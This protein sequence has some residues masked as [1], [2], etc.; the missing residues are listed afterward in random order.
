MSL[1]TAQG[2]PA[3]V[4]RPI[5]LV[6]VPKHPQRLVVRWLGPWH[7][8][9]VHHRPEKIGLPCGQGWVCKECQSRKMPT[10]RGYTSCL[11]ADRQSGQWVHAIVEVS[12]GLRSLLE[13][14]ELR[15]QEWWLARVQERA[16]RWPTQGGLIRHVLAERLPEP[17]DVLAWC[18][19]F[20]RDP[21]LVLGA[22]DPLPPVQLLA[23]V[24]L[25]ESAPV[26]SVPLSVDQPMPTAS[27]PEAAALEPKRFDGKVSIDDLRK[28][29]LNFGK[30]PTGDT[31][32]NGKH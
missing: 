2:S 11:V 17:C 15:G 5:Q 16:N 28:R 22:E 32:G 13:G 12:R 24:P 27:A 6:P 29:L 20:Y 14:Q 10:W 25:S 26:V 1:D 7:G 23:P 18:R 30:L 8:L 3:P 21:E 19:R 4:P 9:M 31:N